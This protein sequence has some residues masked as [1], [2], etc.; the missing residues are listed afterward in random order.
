MGD[1][2]RDREELFAVVHDS[3]FYRAAHSRFEF[4]RSHADDIAQEVVAEFAASDIDSIDNPAGW[5]N[6]VA[7]NVAARMWKKER[8]DDPEPDGAEPQS[9]R[10]ARRA[11]AD[12]IESGRP[13]SRGGLL[14]QQADLLIGQLSDR[15]FELM[16]GIVDGTSYADIAA[17]MNYANADVVK[18]T[19]ARIRRKVIASAESAGI[20]ADW[21]DHPRIY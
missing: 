13:A 3:A 10:E 12:F 20:D 1:P 11:L 4:S 16:L 9:G 21:N 19:V 6:H 18:S 17:Q 14:R 2:T 15:E 7:A 8:L 5:A